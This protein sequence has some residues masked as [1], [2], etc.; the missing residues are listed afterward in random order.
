[1]HVNIGSSLSLLQKT[2]TQ[3]KINGIASGWIMPCM[4]SR[5]QTE[6]FS[7]VAKIKNIVFKNIG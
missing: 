1:M 3:K 4:R 7:R 6:A 2:I 5:V